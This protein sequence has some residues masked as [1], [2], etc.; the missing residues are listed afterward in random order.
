MR[1]SKFISSYWSSSL[2]SFCLMTN[3]TRAR[4]LASVTFVICLF[5]DRW[6]S[7]RTPAWDGLDYVD[8]PMQLKLLHSSESSS[9][10]VS[11]LWKL[12]L[13]ISRAVIVLS[14]TAREAKTREYSLPFREYRWYFRAGSSVKLCCRCRT[15][16]ALART[17][18]APSA[19]CGPEFENS[20][21]IEFLSL[22]YY[23]S[24]VW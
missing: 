2:N 23:V 19:C 3:K 5:L 13:T 18:A 16:E 7:L 24:C 9:Q 22:L 6:T 11:S 1:F 14:Q 12:T 10:L 15:I 17:L 8:S 4:L 21:L 20:I